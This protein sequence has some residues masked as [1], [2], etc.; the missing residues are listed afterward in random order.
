MALVTGFS[1][2][3]S[4]PNLATNGAF[5]IHQRNPSSN[6]TFYPV[7]SGDYVADC[8][9]ISSSTTVDYV[10][11]GHHSNGWLRFKGYG[12]KGQR[13]D[14]E[15]RDTSI[16]GELINDYS[17][18]NVDLYMTSSAR[19]RNMS[20]VPISSASYPKRDSG[21]GLTTGTTYIEAN[22]TRSLKPTVRHTKGKGFLAPLIINS[23]NQDGE[24]DFYIYDFMEL[25][26]AFRDLPKYAP[27]HYA[28]DLVRCQRYYQTHHLCS[29]SH[30]SA[31]DVSTFYNGNLGAAYTT[32]TNRFNFPVTMSASP[33]F[34]LEW[35]SNNILEISSSS[36]VNH[37]SG[38]SRWD[39]SS[40]VG[41]VDNAEI[42][43]RKASVSSGIIKLSAGLRINAEVV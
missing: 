28:D 43:L 10:E 15:N 33:S 21:T 25:E 29:Y 22:T 27:V 23:L 26:G 35:T 34:S 7:K 1:G 30:F 18:S 37:N 17:D 16:L 41:S 3:I 6:G 32:A 4:P 39:S 40:V 42:M 9:K 36:S 5:R 24:F 12:K 8:W 20:G 11:C 13:I 19:V 31:L 38:P 2:I 14:I